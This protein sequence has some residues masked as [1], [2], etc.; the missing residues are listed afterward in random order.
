MGLAT[1]DA[2]GVPGE[3]Q[4]RGSYPK[5]TEMIGGGPFHLN[6]GEWTDDT[7]MAL[8]LGKSLI[9]KNKFDPDDIMEKFWSWVEN[10]YMSSNGRMFDIGDT[11]SE[12]LCHYKKY[13]HAYAG[14]ITS[15]DNKKSGNGSIMR[16][17]PIPMFFKDPADHVSYISYATL[18]SELTHGSLN[19]KCAC[20]YLS[21]LIVGALN[22]VSKEELLGPYYFPISDRRPI[23]EPEVLD[24]A[25]GVYK[26]K[27]IDDIK[28]TGYVIH[29]LE[30]ALWCFYTTNTFEEGCIKAVNLGE[31]TDTVGAVYCQLAGA[32]YGIAS[33]PQRW[34]DKVVLKDIIIDVADKLYQKRKI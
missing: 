27:T 5:I 8:C 18:S 29:T 22:G 15:S 26:T 23:L 4:P 20:C 34:L 13:K 32:Y 28:S 2:L 33:I 10:G 24:V 16:L 1:G 12:A 30:S 7:S 14:M 3:F 31:D 6:P 9:D 25:M 17:A 19:C 11:T 21:T